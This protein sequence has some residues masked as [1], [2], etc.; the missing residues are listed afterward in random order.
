MAASTR[1]Q[2]RR[3]PSGA[4]NRLKPAP[5]D[6]LEAYGLPSKGETRLHDH[7]AQETYYTRI[8]ERYMKFCA[9][10]NGGDDLEAAFSS[11]SI[12]P[13]SSLTRHVPQPVTSQDTSSSRTMQPP[14]VRPPTLTSDPTSDL[15]T[16][17]LAMRKLREAILGSRR[18]DAFAQ[19]AYMFIIHACILTRSWESY[20]PALQYLLRSIHPITPLSLPEVQEFSAYLILDLAC[21]QG[22]LQ[23]AFVARAKWRNRDRKVAAVLNALVQDDWVRFWRVK[24]AVDGYR[25]AILEFAAEGMRVHALKCL[26]RSYMAVEKGFVE[27]SGDAS[28]EELVKGGVGWELGEGD[29]V[30]IRRPKPK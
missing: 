7:K 2:P 3:G 15:P 11:L 10:S 29:R 8:V 20:Q 13:T 17:I 25:R 21:R 1:P 27:R 24:R 12:K 18:C 6:P 23:D 16:I 14:P 26:G 22:D 30:V 28:W 5:S 9:S 19:R 4:W